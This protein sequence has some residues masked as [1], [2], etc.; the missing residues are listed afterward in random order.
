MNDLIEGL[1]KVIEQRGYITALA[2][3]DEVSTYEFR[4]VVSTIARPDLYFTEF[5]NFNAIIRNPDSVKV[6]NKLYTDG[7]ESP[8]ICQIWGTDEQIIGEATR[9][10]VN[11]GFDGID[12]NLGCPSR[13][14]VKSGGCSALIGNYSKVESIIDSIRLNSGGKA[15]SLKTRLGKK[16]VSFEWIEFILKLPVDLVTI[17]LRTVAEAS[18]PPA[19][20]NIYPKIREIAQKVG[21]KALIIG[22]GDI[23]SKQIMNDTYSM[24]SP[25]GF[26][27][28]R[29]IFKD[30]SIFSNS[31][32]SPNDDLLIDSYLKHI[33]L[34]RS[35]SSS[36]KYFS[37]LKK[38]AK[39]YLRT[40]SKD[41]VY[42][43]Y[44]ANSIESIISILERFKLDR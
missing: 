25:D 44:Q 35:R 40:I 37:V 30:I 12:L 8:I 32:E 36:D 41:L 38:F 2:P 3:M 23:M 43:V 17:H 34:W 42:S 10:I 39:T 4:K 22:N 6:K 16:E 26:M 1:N 31:N 19:K 11:L 28:G 18:V 5:I 13:A 15:V 9:N 24:Y 20:W 29:G 21:S 14:V 7:L 33:E 27:I